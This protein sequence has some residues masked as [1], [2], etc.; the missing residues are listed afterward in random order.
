MYSVLHVDVCVREWV[1]M[2]QNHAPARKLGEHNHMPALREQTI[3]WEITENYR[4]CSKIDPCFEAKWEETYTE[5]TQ[6]KQ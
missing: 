5:A 2:Q 1:S 3:E 4:E 6:S